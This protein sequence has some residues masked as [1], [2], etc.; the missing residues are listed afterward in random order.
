MAK[1]YRLEADPKF[2]SRRP[3]TVSANKWTRVLKQ[4]INEVHDEY[5]AWRKVKSQA[6]LLKQSFEVSVTTVVRVI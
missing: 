4:V 6:R 3:K 2:Y 5:P 1:L